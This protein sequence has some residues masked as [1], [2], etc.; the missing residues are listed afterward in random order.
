MIEGFSRLL[1]LNLMHCAPRVISLAQELHQYF[2]AQTHS[3]LKT[4]SQWLPSF[5]VSNGKREL[6][7]TVVAL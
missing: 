1:W 7:E 6:L 2:P 4:T 5:A 3:N